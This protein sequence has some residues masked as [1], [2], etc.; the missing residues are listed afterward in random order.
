MI[1]QKWQGKKRIQVRER[2]SRSGNRK[3]KR[4]RWERKEKGRGGEWKGKEALS[5]ID[6]F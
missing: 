1:P 2:N 5:C 6:L 3:K 4:G